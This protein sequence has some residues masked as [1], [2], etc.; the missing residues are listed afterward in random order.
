MG[1]SKCPSELLPMGM[2]LYSHQQSTLFAALTR[3]NQRTWVH[4]VSVKINETLS[5]ESSLLVLYS[6]QKDVYIF[7][8]EM[9]DGKKIQDNVEERFVALVRLVSSIIAV[10][11]VVVT[12]SRCHIAHK[13]R[14]SQSLLKNSN[15]A[16]KKTIRSLLK[17]EKKNST[18]SA[19]QL[20]MRCSM[21]GPFHIRQSLK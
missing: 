19:P 21:I 9:R 8:L 16:R 6:L 4:M 7:K 11:V 18:D 10:A 17:R 5:V 14:G 12:S 1:N 13:T 2:V 20:C 3:K 15:D